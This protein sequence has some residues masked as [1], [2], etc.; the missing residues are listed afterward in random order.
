M[1]DSLDKI[2][3]VRVFFR[4]VNEGETHGCGE[5]HQEGLQSTIAGTVR[6]LG[7]PS[8]DCSYRVAAATGVTLPGHLLAPP[9]CC[10]DAALH[11]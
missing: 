5:R 4:L 2:I 6:C 3:T 9:V 7:S 1:V 10:L 11:N 8:G